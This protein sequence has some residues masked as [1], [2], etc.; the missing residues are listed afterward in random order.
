MRKLFVFI[1]FILFTTTL[2]MA[3][4]EET[5]PKTEVFLGNSYIRLERDRNLEGF[6]ASMTKNISKSWGITGDF[7]AYYSGRDNLYTVMAGPRYSLRIENGKV[8]PFAHALFGTIANSTARFAVAYG[9]G[10]DIKINSTMAVRAF[11]AD[12]L[13]IHADNR[14]TDNLR[15]S[16]GLVFHFGK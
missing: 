6:N 14:H 2:A 12:Y 10:L 16:F 15:L 13:Q 3:Q 7:G 5:T 1:L 4:S 11:Q 9:G 8:I